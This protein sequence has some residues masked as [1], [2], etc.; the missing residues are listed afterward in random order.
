MAFRFLTKS[1]KTS[2]SFTEA[3]TKLVLVKDVTISVTGS[4]IVAS[5][6]AMSRDVVIDG[7]V[8][9]GASGVLFGAANAGDLD[10]SVVVSRTGSIAAGTFGI[11]ATA[12][13]MDL[14]NRGSLA[15][16][17]AGINVV[18]SKANVANESS[19]TSSAGSAV[20]VKGAAAMVVN[21]GK[22][23]GQLDALKLSG[24]RIV[25]TNNKDISSATAAGIVVD[26]VGTIVTNNGS[27]STRGNG[28]TATGASEIITNNGTVNS[29]TTAIAAKGKNAIVTNSGILQASGDGIVLS[30]AKGTVTSTKTI[31]V[32]GIAIHV[33]A[34][35][36]I[37]NNRGS[38][39][40]AVGISVDGDSARGANSGTISASKGSAVDFTKAD[41]S[42]FNNSGVLSATSGITFKGGDGQQSVTNSGTLKGDVLLGGGNDYFDGRAGTVTGKVAGGTGNDTYV[43]DNAR[44]LL[45]EA[46][47]AGNDLVISHVSYTLADNFEFLTLGGTAAVN[48]AG[49][50][51]ANQIHGNSAANRIDGK[52]GN[53][54]IWGH[55]GADTL[56]G[57]AGSDHFVFSTGDGRDVI[58]DFAA[59]GSTHDIL[60]LTTV[61]AITDFADLMKNHARQVGS[62]V[63]IDATGG[64]SIL[65]KNVKLGHLD[66]G[67]FFF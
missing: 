57:G 14:V 16:K 12:V 35:D 43:I 38:L 60:D 19:I 3:D 25:M 7:K 62:D 54:M 29:G 4:G 59:S 2:V 13:G 47:T 5:G 52:A 27:I 49:N 26:G 32:G 45:V 10:G 46:K 11:S 55:R 17:Q 65:L 31:A 20:L 63:M 37:V 67:D 22:M 15:G 50:G 58:T 34:D 18:G 28:V 1:T 9:A 6:L 41:Q 42:S 66:K 53:D 61:K 30:G 44:T 56:T 40:G 64:D 51:L 24:D 21:N 23:A 48:G 36:A 33:I 8:S 39:T